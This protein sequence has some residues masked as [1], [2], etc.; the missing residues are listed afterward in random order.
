[1]VYVVLGILEESLNSYSRIL[2][3]L[4]VAV[5]WDTEDDENHS[6]EQVSPWEIQKLDEN[7]IPLDYNQVKFTI[8]TKISTT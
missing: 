6:E 7:E 8:K 4:L 5:T 1:M 3:T 2:P